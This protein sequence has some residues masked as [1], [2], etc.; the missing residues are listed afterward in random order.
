[1]PQPFDTTS[2]PFNRLSPKEVKRLVSSLDVSYFRRGD[3]V[4]EQDAE[5]AH[6]YIVLKGRVEE[7]NSETKEV[8]AQYIKDDIFDAHAVLNGTAKHKYKALEDTLCY[9][10]P[11]SVFLSAYENNRSF[12]EYFTA[13]FSQRKKLLEH[14]QKQKNLAEFIL[15]QIDET[16]IQPI[17]TL[18]H[19]TSI[20]EATLILKKQQ[21][22]CALVSLEGKP[23][24]IGII[25]RTNLLHAIVESALP[26]AHPI[27]EVATSPVI[28]VTLGDY[29]FNAMILMTRDR[30]KRVRVTH[31]DHTVGMLDMTQVLSLFSTH[32]HVL[33]LQI[34]RA[35]SIEELAQ[36]A[37]NQQQLV[38]TLSNNG[39]HTQF[40]MELISA[41]NEKIIEKAFQ[42][43]IPAHRHGQCCLFVMGSEGRGEQILKTDQDNGLIV[44]DGVDW[45]SVHEDMQTFSNV[46]ARLEY[47]ACPGHVMVN[48]PKWVNTE[49]E[50]KK[51]VLYL[52]KISDESSL[53][54]LAI[55][56][57]SHA[58]A[59]NTTLIS[60]ITSTLVDTLKGNMLTLNTFIRPSLA[61]SVPLTLF[62]GLKADKQGLDVKKG[63]IF[64][65]VHGVRTLALEYGLPQTNTF[66]RLTALVQS[67][68]IDEDTANN[69]TEA[70]KLFVKMRLRQQ[71]DDDAARNLLD[72]SAL[73]RTDRDLLRH[74]LSEVKAFKERLA[75]HYQVRD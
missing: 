48:N 60:A 62:G 35:S 73:P 65:L 47:P 50:W 29:L 37:N 57:D 61:F 15:T 63:G 14:A 26:T 67:N 30:V 53:M 17:L 7:L 41:V 42:L 22:D 18:P 55:L 12:A 31:D 11:K 20:H 75:A 34:N 2:P 27:G 23:N 52:S 16:N 4:I 21:Q 39:I 43:T 38:E 9:V 49:S 66:E 40:V 69:L 71:L 5:T 45:P 58:V 46:L 32:S 10:L 70:L 33:S 28:S 24:D 3:S 74:S 72:V 36:A 1:M 54:D 8:F 19:E 13:S 59:G 25:T 51:R 68:A 56:A 6:L 64:P 44:Q